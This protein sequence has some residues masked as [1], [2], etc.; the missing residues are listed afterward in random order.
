MNIPAGFTSQ[1]Q[2]QFPNILNVSVFKGACT[3]NC[4]HC[5]VGRTDQKHREKQF[6]SGEMSMSMFQ[7]IVDEVSNYPHA[8]LRIHSVG[9][10]IMWSKI[11]E[12]ITYAAKKGVRTWLFT[13][14]VTTNRK[15]LSTIASKCNIVEVS[16]NS[17]DADD[18]IKTKGI[19]GYDNVAENVKYMANEIRSNNLDTRLIVSRVESDDKD[20]DQKFVSYWK[21]TKLVA[22]AFVR[23]YHSYNSLIE[24]KMQRNKTT[25]CNVHWGRFNID[26]NGDVVVCFNELFKGDAMDKSLILG[27]LGETS[28]VSIWQGDKLSKI[29]CSQLEDKPELV[30][31]TKNLPCRNCTYCQ[32]LFSDAEK[33]ENQVQKLIESQG[34]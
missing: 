1:E 24:D 18:Y 31:F 7:K 2:Y 32:P 13:N 21:E 11:E 27:N 33:S 5:P 3:A 26:I 15:L 20:Y 17:F 9:E 8:T 6:G 29:R 19:D 12:G 34:D 30:D 4:V 28:I 16:I 25:A 10:P 22:D 23:S 14:A